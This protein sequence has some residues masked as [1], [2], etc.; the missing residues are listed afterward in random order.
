VARDELLQ[1]MKAILEERFMQL[2]IMG[3]GLQDF[4]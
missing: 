2:E 4:R 1:K 3:S